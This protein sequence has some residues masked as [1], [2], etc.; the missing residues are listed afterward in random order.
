MLL[1]RVR[2]LLRIRQLTDML[3]STE[4]VIV[5]LARTVEARDAYTDA[6]LWRI[7]EYSCAVMRALGASEQDVKDIAAAIGDRDIMV[8][9]DEIYSKLILC[10]LLR[11]KGIELALY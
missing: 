8:L 6:H 9:S 3:E 11:F 4:N 10:S 7:A 2:A 5:A 1:A